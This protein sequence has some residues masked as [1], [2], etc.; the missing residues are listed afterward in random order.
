LFFPGQNS[1]T[2][3]Q[4]ALVLPM[5]EV[6]LNSYALIGEQQGLKPVIGDRVGADIYGAIWYKQRFLVSRN[7]DTWRI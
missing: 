4:D 5:Y 7:N 2:N 6:Q 1:G 3:T